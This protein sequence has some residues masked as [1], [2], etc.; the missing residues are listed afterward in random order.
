MS[1]YKSKKSA[2][3]FWYDFQL[4]GQRFHG[5]TR[6]TTR[7]EA[8]KVEAQERE[9]AKALIKAAQFTAGSLQIDHVADRYWNERGQYHSGAENTARGVARLVEYFGKTTLLTDITDTE[10][11][12]LVAWRRAATVANRDIL[13]SNDTVNRTTTGMLRTL[14]AFSKSEGV[15]FEREPQ[16]RRHMLA[17]PPERVRELHDDEAERIDAVMRDDYEPFFTFVRAT[18]MRQKECVTLRWDEVNWGAR[19]IVKLGKGGRRIVFPITNSIREI[20]WPLQAH[21]PVH[22]FTYVAQK[23]RDGLIRGKRYP[24]TMAG[25]KTRWRRLRAEA[26]VTGFRFHDF[27]HD[28]ATKLLRKTGNL[29]LV[30]RALNHAD[31]TTTARYAHVLDEEI[32]DGVEAVAKSREKPRGALRKAN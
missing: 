20:L 4:R 17:K 9:R 1:V 28:F 21:H 26:G 22:V 30:S 16:W 31:I 5:S 8:E 14:F 6:C 32:A 15:R 27:R 25:V 7:R 12:K 24:L 19:Q 18:G 29:K 10:V 23:S 13:V 3:Y 11:A 2:P